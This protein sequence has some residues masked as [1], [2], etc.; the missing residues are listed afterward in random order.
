MTIT[1][2][3]HM[4]ERAARRSP[5]A[6]AISIPDRTV[7]YAELDAAGRHT[8]SWLRGRGVRRGDRVI[9]I[10]PNR[11]VTAVVTYACSRIG[12][13][14]VILHEEIRGHGLAH[15]LADAEP[16]L[17]ITDNRPATD[18]AADAG[19]AVASLAEAETAGSN[20]SGPELDRE[21][22]AVD[23]ICLTYTSGSTGQA[24]AVVATHAQLVFAAQAIHSQLGYR[25]DDVV[26]APLPLSFDYGLYQVYLA[27]LGGAHLWLGTA[28]DIGPVFLRNLRHSRAT[29]LPAVP[30]L[31]ENL[32]RMLQRYGGELPLRLLT[33]TGAAMQEG[34]L[35][36]LRAHIPALR[37]QLM[38]GLTECKR[39]S[40]MPPDEDLRRPGASGLPLPGTEVWVV[41]EDGNPVPPGTIGELVV[42]GPHVM[43]GYWRRPELTEQRFPRVNGLFPQLHSGDYGWLDADGYLYF[44]GRRDD[45]YKSR[46]FRIS[47]TEIE[48]AVCRLPGVDVA[49]VVP[50]A[51]GRPE[52]VLF[53]VGK[54]K[55]VELLERLR[56]E[57]EPYKV[58][59]RCLAL[60][61]LPLTANGKIDR[62]ALAARH[63]A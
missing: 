57:L 43:A 19:I 34:T 59:D 17:V 10:A 4:L 11:P 41:D 56:E 55:P 33:N 46:G 53:V 9:V 36:V 61:E 52:P 32:G 8:A 39:V 22:L 51:P 47:A 31:A 3:H 45:I 40:I 62:N 6:P 2:L 28:T 13:V 30:S 58:P 21:P 26:Y 5:D 49:A 50:P 23:P 20:D 1:L 44:S 54:W 37:V 29:I 15:V 24:K 12:A 38:F 14:F 35:A 7:S 60:D 18:A 63:L 25:S 16:A 42:R 27:A 48:A